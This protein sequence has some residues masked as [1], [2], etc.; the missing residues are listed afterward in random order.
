MRRR[1]PGQGLETDSVTGHAGRGHSAPV[2]VHP[3]RWAGRGPVRRTVRRADDRRA[4]GAEKLRAAIEAR[5]SGSQPQTPERAM[6]AEIHGQAEKL[7]RQAEQ[8]PRRILEAEDDDV[9]AMLHAARDSGRRRNPG[10]ESVRVRKISV[11]KQGAQNFGQP[12]R[13]C[14]PRRPITTQKV[15]ATRFERA[16]STSRT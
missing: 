14:S 15:G 8:A 4:G 3:A 9:R 1:R 10:L 11:P 2:R 5:A 16:T 12:H 7:R 6:H 13:G